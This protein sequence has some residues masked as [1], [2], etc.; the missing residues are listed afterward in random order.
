MKLFQ[1]ENCI[2][3]TSKL[4]GA[5]NV[6]VTSSTLE[7]DITFHPDYPSL[8]SISDTLGKYGVD[9]ISVKIQPS[10]LHQLP[11]PCIVQI[12][13]SETNND[14]FSIIKSIDSSGL[15]YYDPLKLQWV[16]TTLKDFSILWPTG[17]V[18]FTDAVNARGEKD[19]LKNKREEYQSN[20]TK[21]S[22]F[23]A[24]PSLALVLIVMTFFQNGSVAIIPS[25]YFILTLSGA[26][27]GGALVWYELDQ[28]N[29]VLQ[30]ICSAGKKVNCGALLNSKASK[31]LGVSW[32]TIGLMYF[33]VS[34]FIQML[35]GLSNPIALSLLAWLNMLAVPFVLFSVYYQWRIAKQWCVL[36]LSIQGVLV[37]QL[38]TAFL[39]DWH[40]LIT[41]KTLLPV[42][43]FIFLACIISFIIV[44]LLL[45][46][47]RSTKENKSNLA[48]LQR[49]KHNPQIFEALLE[50]QK[51]ITGNTDGL[52]ILL[53]NSEA[54]YKLIKVCNPY[55]G[56]C[57]KAHLPIDELLQSH[58]DLQVQI[59]FTAENIDCDIRATTVKHLLAIAK[60]NSESTVKKALDEWYLAKT[61]DYKLFAIKFPMNGELKQQDANVEAMSQWCNDNNIMFTPTFF[62]NGY[63]LPE[64][65]SIS[66]LKYL[67][68]FTNTN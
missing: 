59:I 34:L 12:K 27:I 37:L 10:K 3:V 56:P 7:K 46:A 14:L 31:V 17:I 44:N 22:T 23:L 43:N 58:P 21:Y 64:M 61:K 15:T 36:C 32:S 38:V 1:Q 45:P 41:I 49:L 30:Q 8:L 5:L 57:A 47:L 2:E 54:I 50:K 4:L 63:Q 9:N 28:N 53:G 68:P 33:A 26:L 24:M 55:C 67:I 19:Y 11:L 51:K 6:K 25:V 65:Y 13:S 66:D 62:V 39:N 18:L 48:E 35:S 52:G 16:K 29:A 60:N 42:A 20:I 40:V